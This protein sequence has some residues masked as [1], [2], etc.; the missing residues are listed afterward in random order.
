MISNY[1]T[2]F[3]H[4]LHTQ[5]L[6]SSCGQYYALPSGSSFALNI[7]VARRNPCN[8]LGS[9]SAGPS[10]SGRGSGRNGPRL[11][12]LWSL[13]CD[14]ADRLLELVLDFWDWTCLLSSISRN[15]SSL[16]PKIPSAAAG[17]WSSTLLSVV[18]QNY[19]RL[20]MSRKEEWTNFFNEFKKALKRLHLHRCLT[21]HS[22]RGGRWHRHWLWLWLSFALF[23]PVQ[24]DLLAFRC[25][26]RELLLHF[27]RTSVS[28]LNFTLA[29]D[30]LSHFRFSSPNLQSMIIPVMGC[31]L[32]C[33]PFSSW[34]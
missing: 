28:W 16:C 21:Y 7:L 19:L 26:V 31:P 9:S 27:L 2:R 29:V 13:I 22:C 32:Y 14:W 12:R 11:I 6:T 8:R 25:E 18:I 23:N 4:S 20:L 3:L 5:S 15:V 33:W 24:I 34:V 30:Q 10:K 1:G 17:V